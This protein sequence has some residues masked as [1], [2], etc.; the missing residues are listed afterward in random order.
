[1]N[2]F[3]LSRNQLKI[4]AII[5]MVVDHT[6]WGFVDF[7]SPLGQIMHIF[8]RLTLPIMCFFIAEGYRH[9]S[10]L[11]KYIE[12]MITFA[13][14]SILPFYLF[15]H[16]EYEYRQN[17][18]FD[19]LL[20]LLALC[21]MENKKWSK[22]LRILLLALLIT[23]S[24]LIGGWI[25]MPII[26]VLIFYY[27]ETFKKKATWFSFF[28]VLMVGILSI[29]ILLNQAYHFSKYDW[30]VEERL[31]LLG[32]VFALIPL[33]FYNG[34]KGNP[35]IS[36]R[37]GKYFFYIFYPLHFLIL[38][39][40]EKLPH[41]S[42]QDIYIGSH[43]LA[44]CLAI[45]MFIYA[46]RQPSSRAQLGVSFFMLSGA[47]YVYGFLLEITT[48]TPEGVYTATKLQYFAEIL[49]MMAITYCIQ[50]LTHIRIPSF[51]YAIEG[52]VSAI[53]LYC[54]FTYQ[55]NGLFYTGITINTTSGTFPRMEVL[56]YGPAFYLFVIYSVLVCLLCVGVGIHA[57]IHGGP[58]QRKRLRYLLFAMLSMWC[59]YLIKPLNLTNGY[60]IPSMFIP[61]TAYFVLLALVRYN[62]LDS[63]TLDF[64]NALGK[65]K[66][67]I[68]IIDRN[69]KI[70]YHNEWMHEILGSFSRLDDCYQIKDM[71]DVF[72]GKVKRL[73]RAGHTY[74]FR[75]EPLIEQNHHTGDILWTIDLT[76]HYEQLAHLKKESTHDSLTGLHNRKWFEEM[77]NS[78]FNEHIG[79][80]FCMVDLDHFKLVNDTYGHKVGD[81]TIRI[82][83]KALQSCI[84]KAT[85]ATI[86]TGRLGGD[87]FCLFFKGETNPAK[88]E[89]FAKD[90][91]QTF[92]TYLDQ[93]GYSRITSLSV[94]ITIIHRDSITESSYKDSYEQ[95]DSALYKA[96]ESG[97]STYKFYNSTF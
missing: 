72:E 67:G 50:E 48:C 71:K 12:R 43:A 34:Q 54:L 6:A 28:T 58:L 46:L 15:F 97:R 36:E 53:T 86:Y 55:E 16:E 39:G 41:C 45:C 64:S 23:V 65:G 26:Y 19:L 35:I 21:V 66:E 31:Y 24:I 37:H 78:C 17:I 47:F 13:V 27:M 9:T 73:D 68:L 91:I 32:F 87:E 95:A 10:D 14:I 5:A 40:I 49:V 93:E 70:L 61:L 51:I 2:T 90:L 7:M 52:V 38:Y 88:I 85:G 56:D 8:G 42:F 84:E 59:A 89:A 11:K 63:I 22:P 20:A 60:E 69:H 33:Y 79:G 62:Y 83:A 44:F 75:V 96:K 18:I 57:A 77:V 74:E 94:G 30:V 80:A 1:M 4:I 81:D 92:A 25:I 3:S 76:K 82:S 29:M